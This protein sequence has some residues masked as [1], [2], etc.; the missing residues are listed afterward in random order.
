M[1][2][3]RTKVE[4]LRN[5]TCTLQTELHLMK[6]AVNKVMSTTTTTEK[7]YAMTTAASL[8]VMVGRDRS[9]VRVYSWW[10]KGCR[11]DESC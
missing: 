5:T 10:R 1:Q 2:Q 8:D 3:D 11:C 4:D 7:S 6:D 9:M